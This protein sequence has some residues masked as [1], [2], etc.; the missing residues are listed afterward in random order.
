MRNKKRKLSQI[1]RTAE[2]GKGREK[3]HRLAADVSLRYWRQK[4]EVSKGRSVTAA[5]LSHEC[6]NFGLASTAIGILACVSEI[7]PCVNLQHPNI[8]KP[9]GPRVAVNDEY[10]FPKPFKQQQA[11]PSSRVFF[12]PYLLTSA[13]GSFQVRL[14]TAVAST[15]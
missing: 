15:C 12:P 6:C 7:L 10:W 1:A 5:M 3:E 8:S 14:N 2:M 13:G 9:Q 11:P 4:A